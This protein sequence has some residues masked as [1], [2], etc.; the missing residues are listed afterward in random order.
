[1][2]FLFRYILEFP[3]YSYSMGFWDRLHE[4]ARVLCEANYSVFTV[5]AVAALK[6]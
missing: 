5:A 2:G 6:E 1:M 3:T 4:G